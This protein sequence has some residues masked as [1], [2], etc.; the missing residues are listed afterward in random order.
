MYGFNNQIIPQAMNYNNMNNMNGQMNQ[1]QFSNPMTNVPMPQI[2]KNV[3][4]KVFS[5]AKIIPK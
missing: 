3:I 2:G 1:M 5:N 4:Q